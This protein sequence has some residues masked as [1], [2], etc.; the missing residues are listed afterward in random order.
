MDK[1]VSNLVRDAKYHESIE[2]GMSDD[3]AIYAADELVRKTQSGGGLLSSNM[4]MRGNEFMRMFTQFQS[5]PTKTLN[6]LI[7][8]KNHIDEMDASDIINLVLFAVIAPAM[9]S[10]M[11]RNLRWPWE[12]PE[13]VGKEAERSIV[14]AIPIFGNLFDAMATVGI[15]Q[16]KKLRGV[17]VD[18]STYSYL[19]DMDVPLLSSVGT[20]GEGFTQGKPSKIVEGVAQ[21]AGFPAGGQV[22]RVIENGNI[23]IKHGDAK[24]LITS[25][26]AANK[27]F[28]QVIAARKTMPNDKRKPAEVMRNRAW[29]NRVYDSWSPEKQKRFDKYRMVENQI[30]AEPKIKKAAEALKEENKKLNKPES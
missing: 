29:A 18:K 10:Y 17:P 9:Y 13:E 27:E 4:F 20:I 7:E 24:Y 16:L 11:I 26:K 21:A 14:S 8:F 23:A 6:M 28:D 19:S 2:N 25:K 12:E 1:A 3:D 30:K 15:D 5:D 22:S